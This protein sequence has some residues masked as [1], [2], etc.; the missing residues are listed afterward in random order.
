MSWLVIRNYILPYNKFGIISKESKVIVTHKTEIALFDH[1]T[2]VWRHLY[3]ELRI[4][5]NF[6]SPETTSWIFKMA[7][8]AILD[9]TQPEIAPLD[10]P[11]SKTPP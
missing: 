10:P 5:K 6:I 4:H 8:A 9:L 1:P 7:S 3:I 2:V 11:T